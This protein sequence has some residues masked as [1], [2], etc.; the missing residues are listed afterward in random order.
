MN[1]QCFNQTESNL[2]F[3]MSGKIHNPDFLIWNWLLKY[4][5][6]W[7]LGSHSHRQEIW[8]FWSKNFVKRVIV[9]GKILNVKV[10]LFN[11]QN[12]MKILTECF[13]LFSFP[14]TQWKFC[15]KSCKQVVEECLHM[16]CWTVVKFS[17]EVSH[18]TSTFE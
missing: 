1:R 15:H 8:N 17:N 14:V 11:A 12:S 2:K 10:T 13:R 7:N 9:N 5:E 4:A 16:K 3:E 6:I 18:K